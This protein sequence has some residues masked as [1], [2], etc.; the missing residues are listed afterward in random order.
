[1]SGS[2]R[3][4]EENEASKKERCRQVSGSE[5]IFMGG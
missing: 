5:D 1:M 4:R 2:W 3:R